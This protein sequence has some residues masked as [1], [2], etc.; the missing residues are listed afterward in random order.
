MNLIL[1]KAAQAISH[2]GACVRGYLERI[3]AMKDQHNGRAALWVG[4]TLSA[5]LWISA[6][7]ATAQVVGLGAPPAP[8]GNCGPNGCGTQACPGCGKKGPSPC[9]TCGLRMYPFSDKRYIRQFCYP[10]INPGSCFGHYKTQWTPWGAAC[11]GWGGGEALNYGP[12]PVA[13]SSGILGAEPD[14]TKVNPPVEPKPMT[15]MLPGP[16][17][18]TPEPKP[19]IP[20]PKTPP[21]KP[22]PEAPAPKPIV[23]EPK[24]VVPAPKPVVPADPLPVPKVPA[25]PLPKAPVEKLPKVPEVEKEK[26]LTIPPVPSISPN[27]TYI[28]VA[29]QKY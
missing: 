7:V 16:K 15:P 28:P 29:P 21:V 9:S 22:L 14:P 23:P 17:P 6:G 13:G 20:E 19:V 1:G 5:G 3:R 26:G 10:T 25:D 2:R 27:Q 4:L 24:P 8:T 18:V 12:A 11:P